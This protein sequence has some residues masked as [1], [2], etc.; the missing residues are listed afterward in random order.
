MHGDDDTKRIVLKLI[1][2]S[3][4]DDPISLHQLSQVHVFWYPMNI[5]IKTH[6]I[7][8]KTDQDTDQETWILIS[9]NT[10]YSIF[11]ASI[12]A[13]NN[14]GA[15][16]YSFLDTVTLIVQFWNFPFWKTTHQIQFPK[17]CI[18]KFWT[19]WSKSFN[20][21]LSLASRGFK[22]SDP[23]FLPNNAWAHKWYHMQSW[24][25]IFHWTFCYL[26]HEFWQPVV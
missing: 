20:Y 12:I 9:L 18:L 11:A 19:M 6:S 22:A 2:Y 14:N 25:A 15:T 7:S 26:H 24:E 1:N 17:Q 21:L 13:Y 8:S 5:P 23:F 3:Y 10:K 16:Y 4:A